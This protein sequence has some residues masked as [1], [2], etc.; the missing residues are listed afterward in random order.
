[1]KML[2]IVFMLC[3]TLYAADTTNGSAPATVQPKDDS[4]ALGETNGFGVQLFLVEGERFFADWEKPGAGVHINPVSVAKRGVPICTAVIFVGAG[5]KTDGKVDVTFDVVIRRPDG[6]VYGKEKDMIGAQDK[7]DPAP[8]ALQ[9][10]R[11]FEGIRIE[12]KDPAGVY[13][14][15]VVVKD[16]VKKVELHLVRKFTVEK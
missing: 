8:R 10:A 13:T 12:P 14:V 9:L 5:M 4:I 2:A 16:H 11:D 3:N 6:S 15:E 7:I 1:M